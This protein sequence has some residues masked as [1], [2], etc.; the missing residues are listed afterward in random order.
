M[1]LSDKITQL[2]VVPEV[3]P[4]VTPTDSPGAGT[5]N[6]DN[7]EFANI[8]TTEVTPNL[9]PEFI[10]RGITTP[11]LT[12]TRQGV[13]VLAGGL[14]AG[15]YLAPSNL[16]AT[17]AERLPGWSRLLESG[18]MAI[19]ALTRL[20]IGPLGAGAGGKV[21]PIRHGERIGSGGNTATVIGDVHDGATYLYVDQG[22][23]TGALAAGAWTSLDTGVT[24]TTSNLTPDAGYGWAPTSAPLRQISLGATAAYVVGDLI[25]GETSGAWGQIVKD[26]AGGTV[27]VFRPITGSF[28]D[29]EPLS[30]KPLGGAWSYGFATGANPI[31][32]SFSSFGSVSLRLNQGGRALDFTGCRSNIQ[33]ALSVSN[34]V[35]VT[36]AAQGL[37]AQAFDTPVLS[38][39][40]VDVSGPV[41][42]GAIVGLASNELTGDV[43]WA[44]AG[45]IQHE[46]LAAEQIPCLKSLNL[47][48]GNQLQRRNC[49]SAAG[50]IE[51]FNVESRQGTGSVVSDAE[52]EGYIPWLTRLRAGEISR[53]RTGWGSRAAGNYFEL[54]MPGIQ[55]TGANLTGQNGLVQQDLPFNL[56]GGLNDNLLAT[57]G[58]GDISATPTDN[59][60]ILIHDFTA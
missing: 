17:F 14:S 3:Q 2:S 13:G 48:L 21:G 7:P 22:S 41:W 31:R 53:L 38:G 59:E 35:T 10:D 15:F 49:A 39:A 37:W 24:V 1:P 28:L 58:A 26:V 42:D 18:G 8:V 45:T 55:A 52:L 44:P 60:V 46:Q 57:G 54:Q 51:E 5:T 19:H 9:A 12:R 27:A 33:F 6:L 43:P 36:V 56:T 11:G 32:E 25:R 30:R 34:E 50:G 40:G 20:E 16:T 29:G 47:D 23:A 4:G